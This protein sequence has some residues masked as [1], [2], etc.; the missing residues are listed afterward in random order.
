VRHLVRESVELVTGAAAARD[1]RVTVSAP[2]A[3]V[4]VD[5]TRLVQAIANLLA[6]AARFAPRGS[7]VEV[8][9]ALEA[10]DT[11]PVLRVDVLDR[12]AGVPVDFR[13]SLFEPFAQARP[14]GS[15]GSGLGLATAAAAVR[16]HGGS[17]GYEERTG[18]GARFW[19]RVPA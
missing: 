6:N 16:A 19:F 18:G 13:P 4:R 15:P 9:A 10:V 2:N 3:V 7:Q 8:V 14:A 1:V 11:S 17:I 12:G 5:R